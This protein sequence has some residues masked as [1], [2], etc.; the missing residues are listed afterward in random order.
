M[1]QGTLEIMKLEL[2]SSAFSFSYKYV[3]GKKAKN[4]TREMLFNVVLFL[5]CLFVL[6]GTDYNVQQ[7][8]PSCT[9]VVLHW[10]DISQRLELGDDNLKSFSRIKLSSYVKKTCTLSFFAFSVHN[11]V[12][13]LFQKLHHI[14]NLNGYPSEYKK[15]SFVTQRE[16]L[17]CG[18]HHSVQSLASDYSST[19]NIYR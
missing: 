8:T 10:F 4:D 16:P 5:L 17:Y 13:L 19:V 12:D 3:S 6:K 11:T 14:L 9:Q 1:D 15:E 2:V 7:I 18:K